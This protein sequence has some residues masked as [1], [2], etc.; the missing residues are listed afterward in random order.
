MSGV[1]R[2]VGQVAGVVATVAA[3]VPGGQVIAGIA[4]AAKIAKV[5]TAV[6]AVSSTLGQA[7]ASPPRGHVGVGVGGAILGAYM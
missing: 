6:A 1:L 5:A 3:F 2:T 7:L 4:T